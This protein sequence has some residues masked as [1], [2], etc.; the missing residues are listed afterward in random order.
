[1]FQTIYIKMQEEKI[2][3]QSLTQAAEILKKGG[4]VAFPTETVYGLGANAFDIDAV[5]KIFVAKSR[6]ADNPLIVHI[7]EFEMLERI[8]KNIDDKTY[9]LI[10]NFWPGPLTIIL[11]KQNCISSLVSGGLKTVAVRMP[12]N[13]IARELIRLAGVPIA[14]PSANI[15]GKPSPTTGKAVLEDLQNKIDMIIDGGTCSIGLESTVVD[16]REENPILLRPGG[17]TIEMLQSVIGNIIINKKLDLSGQPIS[18]GTKYRHYAPKA[19]INLLDV[20]Y[21]EFIK[22]V[23]K[24]ASNK[25]I[26]VI[27]SKDLCRNIPK[28]I[29]CI[30]LSSKEDL[31]RAAVN[32]FDA[33]REMD[34]HKVEEIF[35]EVW[36]EEGIGFA[37]MN[38]LRKAAYKNQ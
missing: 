11:Q 13:K 23:K 22:I 29:F 26:G 31:K 3:I 17:I 18:P 8:K 27:A 30:E 6:P 28:N 5:T 38:R 4:L 2:I 7:S 24:A 36:N 10:T 37:L 32:L 19:S 21:D 15:S 9:K 25:F 20:P 16:C 33:L 14:A 1:M 12:K 35:A 34:R